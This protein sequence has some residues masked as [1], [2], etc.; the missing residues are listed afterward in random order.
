M[1]VLKK[2]SLPDQ[3]YEELRT[4]IINLT[5]P[6]GSKVNV[7]EL[8][9]VYGVSS[10]PI[11][12]AINRLQIEGLVVYENNV[13]ARVLSLKAED[14]Y[15]IQ[16]LAV[17]LH[18]AAIRFAMERADHKVLAQEIQ[19][20]LKDYYHASTNDEDVK[21]IFNII[22]A[23][24]RHCGNSRLDNNMKVIQG[25]QLILRYLY[26][27]NQPADKSKDNYLEQMYAAVIAGDAEKIIRILKADYA[28][29]TKV[30]VEAVAHLPAEG[31]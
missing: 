3:L 4:N 25:E 28:K 30:L 23:F 1:P 24:Y 13:G 26:R 27:Q 8:Q 19:K 6:L 29:T 17:I 9:S 31:S 2:Q 18:S 22:G 11:R 10:T 16:D 5:Y 21:C 15:E 14:V 20:Y 12:E 7:N